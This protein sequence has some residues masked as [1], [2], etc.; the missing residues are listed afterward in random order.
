MR[1]KEI[2]KMFKNI[3]ILFSS[4]SSLTVEIMLLFE[5][6]SAFFPVGPR[7]PSGSIRIGAPEGIRSA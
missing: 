2:I 6:E 5:E 4:C 1:H 7:F 3:L